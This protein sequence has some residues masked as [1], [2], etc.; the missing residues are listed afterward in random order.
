MSLKGITGDDDV[1]FAD[2]ISILITETNYENLNQKFRLTSDV[3][4]RWFKANQLVL[5]LMKTNI[6]KCSPLH[7]LQSQLITEHNNTTVSEVHDTE[8]LGVQID[9]Q[10]NWKCHIDQIL[11]ELSTAGFVMRQLFYILNLKTLRMATLLTSFN[12]Q[13]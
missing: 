5:N 13:K 8:F 6:I 3:T 11:P 12:H 4:S 1:L 10:L 7:F 9:N 2:D